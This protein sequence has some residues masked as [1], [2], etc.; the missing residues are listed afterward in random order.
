LDW[1]LCMSAGKDWNGMKVK[2]RRSIVYINGEGHRGI[3][4]RIKGWCIYNNVSLQ[5][6]AMEFYL[7]ENAAKLFND[8]LALIGEIQSQTNTVDLIVFDT[9]SRNSAGMVENSNDDMATIVSHI[10]EVKAYFDCSAL[11]I[12]HTPI[13][14]PNRMRGGGALNGAIDTGFGL[15]KEENKTVKLSCS[16]MK[17]F[18]EPQPVHFKT[19]EV[20][21]GYQDEDGEEVKTLVVIPTLTPAETLL[22]GKNIKSFHKIA[23]EAFQQEAR[24]R[25]TTDFSEIWISFNDIYSKSGV[26]NKRKAEVKKGIVNQGAFEIKGET[27]RLKSKFI[28]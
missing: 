6:D 12:H 28:S 17:D 22:R 24:R 19:E 14:E 4:R 10:D 7:S 27:C 9:L 21:L 20:L 25:G 23:V 8:H 13:N 16:K 11:L 26:A 1:A 2:K 15:K 3:M 5:A 18:E